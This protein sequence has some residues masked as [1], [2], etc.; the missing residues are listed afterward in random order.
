MRALVCGDT[1]EGG[2]GVK[3]RE[4]REKKER[5]EKN[6]GRE[7]VGERGGRREKERGETE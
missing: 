1:C 5:R 2:G 7:R 3:E 6:E 4:R